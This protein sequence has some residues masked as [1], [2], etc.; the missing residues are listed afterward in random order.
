MFFHALTFAGFRGRCS[1]TR[2]IGRELKQLMLITLNVNYTSC[3][4]KHKSTIGLLYDKDILCIFCHFRPL[5]QFMLQH[6]HAKSLDVLISLPES[7]GILL[8]V[9]KYRIL[10]ECSCFI[11]WIKWVGEEIKCEACRA[12]YLLFCNKLNK[13]KNTRRRMLDSC[14][15]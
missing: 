6:D 3:L 2:P 9:V 11:E 4:T 5:K 12:F 10:H 7:H 1:N 15:K 14:C 8:H 13:L